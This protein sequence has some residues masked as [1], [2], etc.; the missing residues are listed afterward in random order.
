MD[1]NKEIILSKCI[2]GYQDT[3][4]NVYN[5]LY[6]ILLNVQEFY[7]SDFWESRFRRRLQEEGIKYNPIQLDIIQGMTT[8]LI[9]KIVFKLFDKDPMYNGVSNSYNMIA[10]NIN[11]YEWSKNDSYIENVVMHEFGHI[12]Y[13][14]KEFKI[15]TWLNGQVL[16]SPSPSKL[17]SESDYEYFSD[18]NE[19]RQRIIPVVKE[20]LDN[21]WSL[22]EVYYLS[23]NLRNDDLYTIYDKQTLIY[24]LD[25]IL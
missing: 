20:M 1:L 3:S 14:Q 5:R 19:I 21:N 15:I 6:K 8:E 12:Q 4:T 2:K 13:F 25:N 11:L 23:D 22:E 10:L 9:D 16:K 18:Q 24:W 7:Y 17:K